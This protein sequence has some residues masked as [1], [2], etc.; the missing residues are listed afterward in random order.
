MRAPPR[1]APR[2]RR[3]VERN[4]QRV[5]DVGCLVAHHLRELG[6][7][8]GA[9]DNHKTSGLKFRVL[10][11]FLQIGCSVLLSDVDVIWLQAAA[12]APRP[13]REARVVLRTC[14]ERA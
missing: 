11:E 10:A 3:G 6:Q 9:T 14:L 1:L 13:S 8:R 5:G 4:D 12:I 7:E 2:R